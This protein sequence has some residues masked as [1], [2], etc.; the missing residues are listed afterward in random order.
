MISNLIFLDID[1]V[2]NSTQ[3]AIMCKRSN[4]RAYWD[5]CP[6]CKSNLMYILEE[7]KDKDIKFVISSTWR[8]VYSM[9]ELKTIFKKEGFHDVDLIIGKTPKRLTSQR[10]DEIEMWLDDNKYK[11]KFAI[12]DDD[13][14]MGRYRDKLFKTDHML[15]LDFITTLKII[16]YFNGGEKD[17]KQGQDKTTD[18]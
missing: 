1:G 15:G 4:Q 6:L 16:E 9:E 2:L 11:G 7:C 3:H 12:I 13:V 8:L 18:I 17:V 5:F 14:D 10:G